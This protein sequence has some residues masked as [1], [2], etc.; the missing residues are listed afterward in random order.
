MREAEKLRTKLLAEADS[1]KI[2]RTRSTIGALL[3]KWL[4][5]HEIDA[6]TRMNYESQIRNYIKLNLGDV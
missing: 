3:D 2:A 5:Q 1:L 4:P 6:T